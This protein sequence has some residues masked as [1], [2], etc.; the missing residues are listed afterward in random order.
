MNFINSSTPNGKPI[1]SEKLRDQWQ[2]KL[3]LDRKMP[4]SAYKVA[5]AISWHINRKEHCTARP[6]INKLANLTGLTRR[7]VIRAVRWLETNGHHQVQRTR[8]GKRN[9][10]NR[11][12]PLLMQ[13]KSQQGS[14][15]LRDRYE[16]STNCAVRMSPPSDIATSPPSDIAVSPEP[17]TEPLTEPLSY[18]N[19]ATANAVGAK[20]G[21][22]EE[23]REED[24]RERKPDY[25]LGGNFLALSPDPV[26]QL[27]RA[28]SAI[29]EC[30]RLATK[31]EGKLGGSRVG[32]ALKAGGDPDQVLQDIIDTVE[33]GGDLGE[34]LS[35]YWQE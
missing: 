14:E 25:S 9:M 32:L 33:D 24:S 20:E 31:H 34:A 22:G 18:L 7:T 23:E 15:A 21:S 13:A 27:E 1:S 4:F 11:Y 3:S 26:V 29:A 2:R 19:I 10:A 8:V 35:H 28:K 16:R 17:L 12:A 30:Y 6:G 5:I